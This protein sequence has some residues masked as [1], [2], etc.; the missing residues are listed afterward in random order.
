[1]ENLTQFKVE[2]EKFSIEQLYQEKEKCER[3][4]ANMIFDGSLIAKLT[5][6]DTAIQIK[7]SEAK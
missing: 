5:L 1:M 3:A 7:E 2:L 4:L 6:I